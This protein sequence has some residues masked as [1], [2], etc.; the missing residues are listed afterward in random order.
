[1]AT[2]SP[3]PVGCLFKLAWAGRFV[4]IS[5]R[6]Q[7]NTWRWWTGLKIRTKPWAGW[8]PAW[9]PWTTTTMFLW[10]AAYYPPKKALQWAECSDAPLVCHENYGSINDGSNDCGWWK[11]LDPPWFHRKKV[12]GY[13]QPVMGYPQLAKMKFLIGKMHAIKRNMGDDWG[14]PRMWFHLQICIQICIHFFVSRLW[15]TP[16]RGTSNIIFPI[17]SNW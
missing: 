1:M 14:Y 12:M 13:P 6:S 16:N 7:K 11:V 4:K 17:N 2:G 5:G 10:L 15:H 8:L 9:F 3:S